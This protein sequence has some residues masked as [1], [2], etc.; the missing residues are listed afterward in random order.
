[1]STQ[2]YQVAYRESGA[3]GPLL[4]KTFD[5]DVRLDVRE[6]TT[7]QILRIRP[8]DISLYRHVL[9]LDGKSYD[10]VGVFQLSGG[11]SREGQAQSL[12]AV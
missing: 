10:L 8:S 5:G 12:F 2:Q 6:L 9:V 11:Q 7:Q 1:M 4:Q 3:R